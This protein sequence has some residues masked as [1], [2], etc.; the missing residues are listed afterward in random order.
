MSERKYIISNRCTSWQF[1][2]KQKLFQKFESF[3]V[4]EV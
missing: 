2:S 4:F 1:I 3:L